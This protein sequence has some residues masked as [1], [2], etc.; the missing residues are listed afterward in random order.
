[1]ARHPRLD[2]AQVLPEHE[3]PVRSMVAA[4]EGE[5]YVA[6]RT[7]EEAKADPKG[8]V[9]IDGDHGTMSYVAARASFVQCDIGQL[10]RLGTEL[11]ALLWSSPEGTRVYFE[12]A[13]EGALT[14][15]L[16]VH[17]ELEPRE[18]AIRDVLLGKQTSIHQ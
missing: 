10:Q 1:M 17:Q 16:W 11:D 3:N 8:V 18:A 9:V 5:K 7:L 13:P 15:E 14:S 12:S 4:S 6:Y 2:K